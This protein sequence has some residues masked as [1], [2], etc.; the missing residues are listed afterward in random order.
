LIASYKQVLPI[1][2]AEQASL[3]LSAI[4]LGSIILTAVGRDGPGT[5]A[6]VVANG[7]EDKPRRNRAISGRIKLVWPIYLSSDVTCRAR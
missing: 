2:A 3:I 5:P 6:H 1:R 4:G 7:G